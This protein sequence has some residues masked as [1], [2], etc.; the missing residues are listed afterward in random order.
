M[1]GH[2]ALKLGRSSAFTLI[3]LLV[4]IAIIAI[5][6]AILFP[7]F[8]QAREKARQTS[9]LSNL[10]QIGLGMAMYTQDY[11]ENMILNTRY[12]DTTSGDRHGMWAMG[13]QAYIKNTLIFS[14]PSGTNKDVR[15]IFTNEYG[16]TPRTGEI[17]V[18]WQGALGA[19]ELIVKAG[20]DDAWSKT[21]VPLARMGRPA[22]QPVI[23][24]ASYI[25]WPDLDRVI[26]PR[27]TPAPWSTLVPNPSFAAHSGSGSNI[28]FADGHAKFRQQGSM[29]VDPT[30]ATLPLPCT[31]YEYQDGGSC[32][33]YKNKMP[34]CPDDDRLR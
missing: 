15:S 33:R 22:E 7:V 34:F 28:V 2:P 11:D 25:I 31:S 21:P 26:N 20:N 16:T 4:V 18:P 24:D 13:I 30:R 10:K 17:R 19:N 3:E 23:S 32:A 27:S 9:C 6:A 12:Y 14:C 5:L 1:K 29:T 8:A